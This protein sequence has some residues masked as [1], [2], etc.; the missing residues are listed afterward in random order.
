MSD[1]QIVDP[2]LDDVLA[3]L[4][5]N[6]FATMNCIQVGKIETVNPNQTCEIQIQIKRFKADGTAVNYPLLVD[7]P[8]FVLSGGGAYLDMPVSVGDYCIILFNDR[9]IDKWWSTA[10]ISEVDTRR[11]HSLS[12]A[13]ALVGISPE[14]QFLNS[15]GSTVRLLGTSGEGSEEFAARQNDTTTS[16]SAE[17]NAF[18]TFWNAFF[19][20][21]TGTPIP[22][23]GNGAPSAFQTALKAAIIT[24]GGTPTSQAGKIDGGSTEV[25][26][27]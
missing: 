14:T 3:E 20:V 11:K 24:V 9:N 15:D 12:D 1:Q 7:C 18:W 25:K 2:E 23:P 26:I 8:Y 6:I 21:I 19:S 17:D 22:E 5:N 27:G 10:N 13:F 4:K 16:T